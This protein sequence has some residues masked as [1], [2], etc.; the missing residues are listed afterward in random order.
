MKA[1]LPEDVA[2]KQVQ[3]QHCLT[4]LFLIWVLALEVLGP[5]D[6]LEVLI[7]KLEL[8]EWLVFES[9]LTLPYYGYI[10]LVTALRRY[11]AFPLV[12]LERVLPIE[13]GIVSLEGLCGGENLS[14]ILSLVILQEGR[15]LLEQTSVHPERQDVL[16]DTNIPFFHRE[17][18]NLVI[19]RYVLVVLRL[20]DKWHSHYGFY[21]GNKS[22][23]LL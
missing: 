19:I 4:I 7:I 10:F 20:A 21:Y 18:G 13:I 17:N 23:V 3:A 2:L 6:V 22:H 16:L 12:A 9:T 8:N 14:L 5:D 15:P 11:G 1:I